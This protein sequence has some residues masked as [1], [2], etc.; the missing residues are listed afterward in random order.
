MGS[1]QTGVGLVMVGLMFF[2]PA[3]VWAAVIA[4]LIQIAQDKVRERR[5]A[6]TVRRQAESEIVL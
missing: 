5:A 1:L 6:R 4:G 3:L 2:V